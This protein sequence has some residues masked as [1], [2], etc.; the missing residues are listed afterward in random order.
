[1]AKAKSKMKFVTRS[2]QA[3]ASPGK[4]PPVISAIIAYLDNLEPGVLLGRIELASSVPG[5][6][7]TTI[8]RRVNHPALS[9]HRCPQRGNSNRQWY[10]SAETIA[11][12]R[13]QFNV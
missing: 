10:G 6:T 3:P 2:G 7:Y 13:R 4:L 1:M 12:Y 9:A 8:E 11:E 5:Y